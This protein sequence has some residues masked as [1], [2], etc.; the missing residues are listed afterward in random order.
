M[1][2]YK[3][4]FFAVMFVLVAALLLHICGT[5]LR[6][7]RVDYGAVWKPY[8]AEPE[9]SL[10]YLYLGS[11]YTYC[12]VNPG[13]VYGSSGLTGYVLSGPEQTLSLTHWYLKEALK[14]QSPQ[15]VFIESTALHFNRYQN[16]SQINV[17]Y[18]PFSLNRL[19]AIFQGAEPDLRTGL[20]FP[21][22]FYHN[23]WKD[24][25]NSWV[26]AALSP[27]DTDALKGY[28][29]I[30]GVAQGLEYGPYQRA[31]KEETV[32]QENLADLEAI[33]ALCRQAGA[34]PVVVF[35]PTYSQL[36]QEVRD[37]I[38]ADVAELDSEAV[39]F[40]WSNAF[41]S[42]GMDPASHL[43]D[44]GHLNQEGARIFSAWLGHFF[45]EE[46]GIAPQAQTAENAAAWQ[47]VAEY[48]QD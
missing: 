12:D 22:Y 19:N 38:R 1:K 3:E 23:R 40:D 33:L 15:Y 5:V 35:H 4:T 28:T 11:S 48:W 39:F 9:N 16:Y 43:Y 44:P 26:E 21:L 47:S 13:V 45:V 14:T 36:P 46:L 8:L 18:M 7:G 2:K 10:D 17:D 37:R 25:D 34:R 6:P 20:L 24:F 30:G 32:Y 31:P 41:D 27:G 29:V 42:I